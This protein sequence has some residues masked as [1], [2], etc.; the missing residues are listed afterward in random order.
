[1]A[2][3]SRQPGRHNTR[4]TIRS[5]RRKNRSWYLPWLLGAATG[6]VVCVA[7]LVILHLINRPAPSPL[8]T[9]GAVC[10]DLRSA[11]YASLYTALSPSLQQQGTDPQTQFTASQRELDII[12]GRVASC[13]YHLEQSDSTHATVTYLIARGVKQAQAA[14]VTLIYEDGTWRIQ[15]YDT[16][17]V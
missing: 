1:M 5:D 13:A 4:A 6:L 11:D 12:S 2:N 14:Q 7:G 16:S 9:A 3:P 15:Q 17:L 8:A 10:N